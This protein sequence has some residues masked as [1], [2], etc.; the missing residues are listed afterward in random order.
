MR[1]RLTVSFLLLASCSSSPPPAPSAPRTPT[2]PEAEPPTANATPTEDEDEGETVG[3]IREGMSAEAVVALLGEPTEKP[4]FVLMEATGEYVSDWPWPSK[5]LTLSM[6]GTDE[7]GAGAAVG[8]IS[9]DESCAFDLPHGLKIGS[10]RAEVEAV[11]GDDFDK[12]FTN[13]NTFIAGSVYG[14]TF[15]EF[16]GDKVVGIFIGAGAE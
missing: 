1:T 11:Y 10:T 8:G 2:S 14:G 16:D 15:Y 13:E 5:G 4:S 7:T 6:M 9:C 3:P 12:D